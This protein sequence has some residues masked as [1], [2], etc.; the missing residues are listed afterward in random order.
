LDPAERYKLIGIPSFAKTDQ[1]WECAMNKIGRLMR[2]SSFG[3]DAPVN[4]AF[5][6]QRN[7]YPFTLVTNRSMLDLIHS[8]IT[9]MQN[10]FFDAKVR[11]GT[12]WY[13]KD[14][15]SAAWTATSKTSLAPFQTKEPFKNRLDEF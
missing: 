1:R 15:F 5:H 3:V 10:L 7:I 13:E 9:I 6:S 11:L 14:K 8:L 2:N 12:A 4:W